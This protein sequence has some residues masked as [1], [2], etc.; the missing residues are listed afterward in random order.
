MTPKLL[1]PISFCCA[2]L[3]VGG[4]ARGQITEGFNQPTAVSDGSTL[5][6]CG[7]LT[8]R[9]A[10]SGSIQVSGNGAAL[11]DTASIPDAAMLRSSQPLPAT[12]TV[13][14]RVRNVRYHKGA[15]ENGVTA[16]AIAN[17]S[18]SPSTEADWLPKRVVG[19]EIDSKPYFTGDSSIFVNYWDPAWDMY[20]WDGVSWGKGDPAWQPYFPVK[21]SYEVTID[22][23][24]SDY[25]ITVRG[26]G[27]LL[28]QASVPVSSVMPSSGD[29]LVIGDRLTDFFSGNMELESVTMPGP[30]GCSP[31]AD[32]GAPPAPSPSP[33]GAPPELLTPDGG[34]GG[35]SDGLFGADS[36]IPYTP[37]PGEPSA[38][39]C[40]VGSSAASGSHAVLPALLLLLLLRR[41]VR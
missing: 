32:A 22:K 9:L 12:Y 21:S 13:T 35:W 15:V 37:R 29:Y 24:T 10:G 34:A 40:N 30:T 31:Q 17:V 27:V 33:D 39:D 19:V 16:L 23:T 3:L 18:P 7:Q 41:R 1:L 14:V 36:G 28:A 2:L 8:A 26:D 20:T 38:C 11:F 5:G 4:A 6:A 25:Q